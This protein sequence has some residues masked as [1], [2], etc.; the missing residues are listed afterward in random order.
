MQLINCLRQLISLTSIIQVYL[1]YSLRKIP[2]DIWQK[3]KSALTF[4]RGCKSH[5]GGCRWQ[6]AEMNVCPADCGKRVFEEG[7]PK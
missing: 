4:V 1:L 7:L 6:E 2:A 3:L 5:T